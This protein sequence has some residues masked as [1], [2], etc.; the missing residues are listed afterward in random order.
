METLPIWYM[1]VVLKIPPLLMIALLWWAVRDAPQDDDG[2]SRVDPA[3]PWDGRRPPPSP[4]RRGCG[5]RSP[6]LSRHF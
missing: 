5:R 4:P 1:L 3:C 2:G 6:T